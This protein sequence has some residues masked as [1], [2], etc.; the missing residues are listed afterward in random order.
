M[1]F[2]GILGSV[3]IG[4]LK[5]VFEIIFQTAYEITANP[6][7]S[8][9]FLSLA[10]NFLVLPLY[11]RADAMQEAARDTEAR[12][13]GGISHIKKTF[14]GSERFMMLQTYYRQN[15]YSPLNALKGSVSLLLEIPFF[16]AAYQF[17]AHLDVLQGVKFGLISDLALPD[18][19]LAIGGLNVNLLPVLMTL[20]NFISAAIY[21]KG[22]PLKTKVQLYALAVFFLVFLYSSPSGLVFYWTLNNVFS[23]C[24]NIFFKIIQKDKKPEKELK[25]QAPAEPDRRLF[26]AAA[27]FLT[28]LTGLLIPTAYLAAS[29]QEY[30]LT[31]TSFSPVWYAVRALCLAA[32]TFLLWF[33]VFYWLASPRGKVRFERSMWVFCGIAAVDYMCFG[34]GLGIVSSTLQFEGSMDFTVPERILNPLILIALGFL[35]VFIARKLRNV[36]RIVLLAAACAMLLMSFLNIRT[37]S[38]SLSGAASSENRK[39]PHFELSKN[40]RNV[41]VLFM[42]RAMAEYM[43]YILNERPELTKI[44]D[45]F[46]F[47]SNTI[48]FGGHTNMA[49]PALMGGYEY[50]PVELNKRG[51][52]SLKE[53]HNESLKVMPVLF[54]ENGF[55]V[56]V[57]DAPYAN[58]EWIPDMSIYDEWPGIDTYITEGY[59]GDVQ[60][61]EEVIDRNLRNFYCFALMKTLPVEIQPLFYDG[62]HYLAAGSAGTGIYQTVENMSVSTGISEAFMDSYEV[63]ENLS[64]MTVITEGSDDNFLFLYNDTPHEAMLLQEPEYVPALSVDNTEYDKEHAG[65]FTVGGK[66]IRINYAEQMMHYQS[67]MAVLLKVGEWLDFLRESGVYDNT[68]IIIVSD[69]GY[70]LYQTPQLQFSAG[71]KSVDGA[72]YYPLLMVKEFGR[73]GFMTSNELMTNADVPTLAFKDVIKDPV[74]PFTGKTIDSSEKTAHDQYI[75][76]SKDWGVDSNNGNVFHAGTWAAVK[77]DIWNRNNWSFINEEVVLTEHARP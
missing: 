56:T 27:V 5:L 66:T 76:L 13:A 49:A 59:F 70:Y 32:G 29:P 45:G 42:D 9:I 15:G 14:S 1:T 52:E 47:Y 68:R 10:M 50:T 22:F 65:R 37:I 31:G 71:G 53:K 63:L 26:I 34:T 57:C 6:G 64:N 67:N 46:T 16:M 40:G 3:I 11:R 69:H 61:K 4:P 51:S 20:I 62:G 30:M 2:F 24:K 55:N 36:P 73:E 28:I 75:L 33:G 19:M 35:M 48:S 25:T 38:G 21:L 74:N 43:P 72:N 77:N 8:I 39:G 41:V 58:Y 54:L 60:D 7:V 18:G 44:Y 17:L 12:L 23:L